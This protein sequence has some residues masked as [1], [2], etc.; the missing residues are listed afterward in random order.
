MF[1]FS[2]TLP[3]PVLGRLS[4]YF[5]QAYVAYSAA[6][7]VHHKSLP[8]LA[9]EKE[10]KLLPNIAKECMAIVAWRKYT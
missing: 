4:T 9:L 1:E 10:K 5:R 3:N 2:P 7:S 6:S 8:S